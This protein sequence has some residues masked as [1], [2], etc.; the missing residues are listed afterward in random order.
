MASTSKTNGAHS[1]SLPEGWNQWPGINEVAR[2]LNVAHSAVSKLARDGVIGTCTDPNGKRRYDPTD[3]QAVKGSEVLQLAE[4]Q[5]KQPGLSHDEFRVGTDLVKQVHGHHERMLPLL[6]SGY[7]KA[8]EALET[9]NNA[10]VAEIVA[11]DATIAALHANREDL[12][13]RREEMISEE[14]ARVVAF[15]AFDNAEQRKNRALSV[16][17]EKLAPL[18]FQRMGLGDPKMAIGMQLLTKIKREQLLMLVSVEGMVDAE[19]REIILKLLE[20]LTAEERE[21]IGPAKQASSPP[22]EAETT[23]EKPNE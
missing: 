6:I 5:P 11:R 3:M 7:A 4:E 14:H 8:I 2:E 17:T 23:T 16:V 12:A 1:S 22:G 21:A 18:V 9:R 19:Q 15:Q 20:P 13:A 10:L